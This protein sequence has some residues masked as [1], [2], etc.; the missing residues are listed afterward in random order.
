MIKFKSIQSKLFVNYSLL[1]LIIMVILGV[2]YYISTAQLLTKQAADSS[3]RLALNLSDKLDAQFRYMDSIAER[4]IS[5]EPVKQLFYSQSN[6][7]EVTFLHN[8]WDI[9]SMLFSITGTPF[10]FY[11]LNI[12]GLNGHFVKFGKEY[13]VYDTSPAFI[14]AKQWTKPV[15]VNDGRRTISTPRLDDSQPIDDKTPL[16]LSLSRA[17]SEVFG[18]KMDS[19]VEV[20]EKYDTIADIIVRSINPHNDQTS[21]PIHAY[22]FNEQG[23]LIY[24]HPTVQQQ[25]KGKEEQLHE[26]AALYWEQLALQT[27]TQHTFT[28][29]TPLSTNTDSVSF[30]RSPFTGWTVA[31]VQSEADLLAPVSTFRNQLLF[32]GVLILLVTLI[33]S[34]FVAK[35]L[36]LPLKRMRKS[37]KTLSLETLEPK[38]NTEISLNELEEL[39]QAF[40]EMCER[41][42]I[43]L[44]EVVAAK[45]HQYQARLF[46]LQAQMNPHFL[47]NTLATISIKAENNDQQDIVAMCYNLSDMLRYIAVDNANPVSIQQ[48]L[49]YT[50][51][52]LQLMK[53]RYTTQFYYEIAVPEN[54]QQLEVPR[55]IIQPIVENCFKHGFKQKPPWHIIIT[56]TVTVTDWQLTISDNGAGFSEE[57]LQQL[58]QL[59]SKVTEP[60]QPANM[61]EQIGLSNIY[62]RLKLIYGNQL[63]LTFKNGENGGA[64]VT[65]GGGK[66]YS[67]HPNNGRRISDHYGE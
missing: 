57:T 11:Q 7:K 58:T 65:I 30:T 61:S 52:Y 29:T 5:A 54:L 14:A 18:A 60:L 64:S 55:L 40:I 24:P 39:N 21:A 3:S 36:A 56:G 32:F 38:M 2:I 1:I 45:S 34:F 26:Q 33:V 49:A 17:F 13:D 67:M 62:Y 8:K 59:T 15:L 16:I 9:T 20:Q 50:E 31:L 23:S 63:L 42:K 53:V 37:I 51:Q 35:G 6:E 44:E 4:V 25:W 12:F 19:I 10:Q 46:A 43:S 48:E 66:L 47:Y 28:M 41:L 22:I 27:Q